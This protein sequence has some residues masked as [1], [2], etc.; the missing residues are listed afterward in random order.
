METSI[1]RELGHDVL[2]DL[3]NN[4]HLGGVDVD[5]LDVD[6]EGRDAALKTADNVVAHKS[7]ELVALRNVE[8]KAARRRRAGVLIAKDD[9]VLEDLCDRCLVELLRDVVATVAEDLAV[10]VEV[11]GVLLQE[12]EVDLLGL[13]LGAELEKAL[14]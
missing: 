11:V 8:S 4:S 13:L 1:G 12:R 2:D 10:E 7:T 14:G 5:T 3:A 6:K 9:K